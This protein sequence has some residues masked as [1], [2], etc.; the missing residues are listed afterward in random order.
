MRKYNFFKILFF[1]GAFLGLFFAVFQIKDF[2]KREFVLAGS[3]DNTSGYAWSENIGWISFNSSNCD[4][5]N[6]NQSN[7]IGACP[8]VGTVMASYGVKIEDP[9]GYLSGSAWSENIGWISFNRSE[10]GAPPAAPYNGAESYIAKVDLATKEVSGWGRALAFGDGWDGW[11]KFRGA[12]YGVNIDISVSPSEFKTWAWADDFPVVGWISFNCLDRGICGASNYKVITSSS[13]NQA[14]SV[15]NQTI[16]YEAYCTPLAG[17]AQ[18]GL[19][20]EY[21][22]NDGDIESRFDFRVNNIN[23]VNDPNPEAST[24]VPN[25]ASS[26]NTQM[27]SAPSQIA[28]NATYYWWARVWDSKSA[29]SGWIAGPSFTTR[30]HAYPWVDFTTLPSSPSAGEVATLRDNSLCYNILEHSCKSDGLVGYQ[31]D[32]DY[33]TGW[34]SNLKGDS[35]TTYGARGTYTARLQLTDNSFAPAGVCFANRTLNVGSPLPEWK[36]VAP[37]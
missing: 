19:R 11:I 22:D 20:W 2:Q 27:V 35:T 37:F 23:D 14:P 33:N 28:Y 17:V 36:E 34:D 26:I 12:S 31:W 29:N 24:T 21:F 9:T 8:P 25:P 13:L 4:P 1:F 32:F 15:Q 3:L 10:T 5:D 30:A 16:E 18:I 6:N 7:G